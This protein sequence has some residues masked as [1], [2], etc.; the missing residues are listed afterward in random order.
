MPLLYNYA[1]VVGA[2]GCTEKVVAGRRGVSIV[3]RY[4]IDG[5]RLGIAGLRNEPKGEHIVI[6]RD[7]GFDT[8]GASLDKRADVKLIGC[9]VGTIPIGAGS[10]LQGDAIEHHIATY[11]GTV[12]SKDSAIGEALDFLGGFIELVRE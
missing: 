11:V 7:D 3:G 4:G 5:C 12:E 10:A 8:R 9:G 2:D 1:P 6:V